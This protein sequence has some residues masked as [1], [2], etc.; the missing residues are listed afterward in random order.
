MFVSRQLTL[1]ECVVVLVSKTNQP[2]NW[3]LSIKLNG[4]RREN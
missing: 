2:Q 1:E 4:S 3:V